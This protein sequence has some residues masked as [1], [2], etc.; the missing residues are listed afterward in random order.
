MARKSISWFEFKG[1]NS[2]SM[3]VQLKDAH[4]DFL[5]GWRGDIEEIAGRSG[6]VWM[7]E[8]T[9]EYIEIKRICRVKESGKRA[10][11][12]WLSGSGPLRFSGEADAQYD[13]QI[14]KKIEFKMV[15]PGDDPIYEFAVIFTCQP[16]PYIYPPAS[17]FTATT[18]GS[19]IPM[20]D[21][22]YGIPR[23]TI[24]GS[25]SF[26]L[27]IGMQ[28][29]HFKDVVGGIII[30]NELGDALSLDGS[31]LANDKMTGELFKIQPGHNSISWIN[32]GQDD[33]GTILPGSISSVTITP[34]W[35]YV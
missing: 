31:Q 3:G 24:I 16:D 22:A 6:F 12:A 2:Q 28:T 4:A 1:I 21:F 11:K 17:D 26:S 18:S 20:P 13:A 10:V 7:G 33:D 19:Q 35:R 9:R 29:V 25:G 27:T 15:C 32:G 34:R 14:I 8:N 5:G 30:D 23:I